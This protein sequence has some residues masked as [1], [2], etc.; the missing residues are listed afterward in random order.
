MKFKII[1][2]KFRQSWIGRRIT[3][4]VNDDN[5][6]QIQQLPPRFIG[7][8]NQ[9]LH[10]FSA[11]KQKMLTNTFRFFV[12]VTTRRSTTYLPPISFFEISVLNDVTSTL[13]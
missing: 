8:Q 9:A 5:C 3:K 13:N 2:V 1:L 10:M 7:A 6:K 4:S 11:V 12:C